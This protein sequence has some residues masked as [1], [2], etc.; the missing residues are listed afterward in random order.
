MAARPRT[1]SSRF[2]NRRLIATVLID[3]LLL[4][5]APVVAPF[6]AASVPAPRASATA[7]ATAAQVELRRL[8][9]AYDGLGAIAHHAAANALLV[10]SHEPSGEPQNLELIAA[11]GSHRRFSNLAGMSGELLLA[12]ARDAGHGT[13]LGAFAPGDVF[14]STAAA[15]AI[16]HVSADGATL[17]NPWV[18]LP[19]TTRPVAGLTVDTSGAFG[20][21]VLAT[22]AE[23]TFWRVNAAGTATRVA[24]AG[25][26]LGA[27][28]TIAD[29]VARY[30]A[31]AGRALIAARTQPLLYA[32]DARGGVSSFAAPFVVKD[33]AV[34]TAHENFFGSDPSIGALF[35]APA[36]AFTAMLGDVVAAQES[37]GTLARIRWSGADYE[38]STIAQTARWSHIAFSPAGVAEVHAATRAYDRIAVV[39]HA[40]VLD[41]GRVEGALWQLAADDVVLDGGDVITS[42]LLVPGTPQVSAAANA[43][44]GGVVEADGDRAPSAYTVSIGAKATLGHLIVHSNPIELP[45]VATPPQAAG[46]RDVSL[47]SASDSIGDFA[48]LRNLSLSGKA[49]V[50]S[51]PPGTYGAFSATGRT[52]LQLGIANSA[53]PAVYNLDALSFGGG[54]ELRIA[55]PVVLNVRSGVTLNGSSAGNAEA[56]SQLRINVAA[57][58]VRLSGTAVL[59]AVVRAPASTVTLEG[60]GRLRG[61]VLSDRLAISG[62]AVLQVTESDLPPPPV[63]RPPAVDAGAD[64][65]IT[66][67]VN[68]VTLSGSVTDDGLPQGATLRVNWSATGPAPV[69]FDSVTSAAT[70][71][72]FTAPG[73]YV[74]R[75]TASDSLLSSSDE[76]VVT[77]AAMN[78][79]PRADAGADQTIALPDAALLNGSATDDGLPNGGALTYAWSGPAGVRFADSTAAS[80]TATFAAPGV[81]T[82][83]L[84]VSDGALSAFDEVVITVDAQNAAPVVNAGADQTIALP[85]VATLSG[86]ATDDA[87][88][89]SSALTYAWSG[90]A[91][92]TF[93][94][95]TAASTTA[96]FAAPGVYTLRLTVSDGALSAFDEVVITV[97]AQNEAPVVNAGA[98]QIIAL[99]NVATLTGSATDDTLPRGSSLTYAW[100]GPASVTFGDATAARTTATFAA[101]GVYTLRLTVSDGALSAF[102]EVVITVD[103]QNAAPIVNAGADQIIALPDVATLTGS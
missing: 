41:A 102:D 82:L 10:S 24:S 65:T 22:T 30:G 98:D 87:L 64:Q 73:T 7:T 83:R 72:R 34:V 88:P 12:T 50:V 69:Q 4:Q 6:A 20:G 90:P 1:L 61:T 54:S 39:R 60:S 47:Q 96:T 48:T 58:Q 5:L 3:A 77:V 57:G 52:A 26:P 13:S 16:A 86:S 44:F 76:V 46:T 32:I 38:W 51:V 33:L 18:T 63:N 84:T 56:P 75:L 27:V 74:L 15:G 19:G 11:D 93:G 89:R 37:P 45:A 25:V 91:R 103:A 99:P 95:A 59:Y 85:N 36:D 42:D 55:G 43:T 70:T 31:W 2:F 81:Y 97:D 92:V 71:A 100:S 28:V 21:D 62:N 9:T 94:D 17:Q 80:T 101:P 67:P 14:L 53:T 29:D 40:P 23:G 35:G 8:S 49:G 78:L 79:P 68:A 66:L